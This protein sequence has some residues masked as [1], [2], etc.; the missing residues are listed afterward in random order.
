M[1]LVAGL[2]RDD[3]AIDI[4]RIAERMVD[5]VQT[6]TYLQ[7]FITFDKSMTGAELD[8]VVDLQNDEWVARPTNRGSFSRRFLKCGSLGY[9]KW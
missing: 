3:E 9:Q 7:I 5:Q 2:M 4:A 6:D 1:V 8:G